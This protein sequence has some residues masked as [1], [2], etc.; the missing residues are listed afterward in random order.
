MYLNDRIYYNVYFCNYNR[1][2]TEG[3]RMYWSL[4]YGIIRF[5]GESGE[6]LY[7]WDLE[8]TE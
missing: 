1:S 5:E 7:A 3:F 4:K 8:T 2:S 6:T